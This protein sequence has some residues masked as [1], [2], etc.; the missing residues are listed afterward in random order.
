MSYFRVET[1]SKDIFNY[2]ICLAR[3][4]GGQSLST[5]AH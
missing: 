1:K 3:A 4:D 2:F 5:V